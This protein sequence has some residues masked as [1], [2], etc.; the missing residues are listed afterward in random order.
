M[1]EKLLSPLRTRPWPQ[2]WLTRVLGAALASAAYLVCIPWDLNNRAQTPG[3]DHETTPVT[4]IGVIGLVLVLLALAAYFGLRDYLGWPL[5]LVAGPPAVLMQISFRTHPGPADGM[6]YLWPLTWGFCTFLIGAGVLV[7]AALARRFRP[8]E[9]DSL[10][11][12]L[13]PHPT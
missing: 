1:T 13:Y 10:D 9:E 3:S 7:A 8:Q 12:L 4:G 11:G 5:L 2:R 6:A